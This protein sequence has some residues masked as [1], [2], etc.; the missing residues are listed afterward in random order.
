GVREPPAT[1]GLAPPGFAVPVDVLGRGLTKLCRRYY[2]KLGVRNR[3]QMINAL[4]DAPHDARPAA[5]DT[6][7][8]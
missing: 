3:A 1:F 8:G 6:N 4:A 7:G 5:T 2:R